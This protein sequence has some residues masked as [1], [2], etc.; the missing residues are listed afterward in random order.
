MEVFN[1][2]LLKGLDM[3]CHISFLLNS[4]MEKS[5][6]E[7][8]I[9]IVGF[10][11]MDE[12]IRMITYFK[13][14][15]KSTKFQAVMNS[16]NGVRLN[17]VWYVESEEKEVTGFVRK[18]V[19]F[20]SVVIGKGFL[21][22]GRTHL[23]F[24][25]HRSD[26]DGISESLLDSSGQL[27]EMR[28]EYLGN[29]FGSEYPVSF[30]KFG[31]PL[32]KLT[33]TAKPPKREMTPDSNPLGQEWVREVRYCCTTTVDGIYYLTAGRRLGKGFNTI[34][35]ENGIYQALT[36]NELL[37]FL[38]EKT[39]GSKALPGGELHYLQDGQFK[40]EF[41]ILSVM[42]PEFMGII[43]EMRDKFPDWHVGVG[44]ARTNSLWDG[45]AVS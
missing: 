18:I 20:S 29:S 17:E 14:S 30:G 23:S 38:R 13:N 11:V 22:N 35:E 7:L 2:E 16:L 8:G 27:K 34:S 4:A 28:V 25:F 36:Q 45:E 5:S 3:Q 9:G 26:L 41:T 21:L 40:I 33:L 43:R 10:V 24:R 44:Q 39:S 37:A 15:E 12:N 6:A 32:Q 42:N 1:E 19:K 31:L